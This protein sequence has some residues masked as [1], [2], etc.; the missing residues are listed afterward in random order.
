M[1]QPG[2][3]CKLFQE[4]LACPRAH[5]GPSWTDA[6]PLH[7]GREGAPEQPEGRQRPRPHRRGHRRHRR[8]RRGQVVAG[9]RRAL[10]R[11]PPPLR[12]DLQPLR[13]A[14]PRAAR[15]AAG[16]AD[17]G[18]APG[19]RRRPHG[20]RAHLALHRRHHDLGRRL[21]ARAL[22]AGGAPC[23]AGSAASRSGAT[24]RRRS[25][26]RS[27]PSRR[28]PDGARLLPAP[29]REEGRHRRRARGL[30]EG[31]LPARPG[32]AASRSGSRTRTSTRR[33]ASSPSC[34]TASRSSP[35][36]RQR[37]VDSLE[38][39]LRHGEGHVELRVE[40]ETEP[41]RFSEA[42]HCAA[43]RHRLRRP[44][45]RPLLLQPPRRR[46]RDLQGLRPHDGDRPRPRHP[47][48]AQD[49]RAGLRQAVPDELL[50][51]LPGRPRAA[52]CGARASRTTCP[53]P[54]CRRSAKRL[55]WDGEPGGPAELAEEVV[56]DRRLLPVARVA[57]LPMHVRVFLSR[58]RSYRPRAPTA[59]A[60]ASRPRRGSS[61]STAARCPRSRRCRWPRPSARFREWSVPGERPGLGAAAARDPRPA[62][63]PR[64]RRPRLPDARP[65]VAHALGRRGAA[66]DAGDGPRR[67]AHEHALRA[68]RA[69]GR[70]SPARRGAGCPACCAASPTRATRWS[71]SSTTAALIASADHVIDLG[72]GPGREGGEVVYEGPVAGLLDEPRSKTGAYLAGRLDACRVPPRRREPR[73]G[74][75]PARSAARART[76]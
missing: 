48:P 30:R 9:L 27:S 36:E 54:S 15:P 19:G 32:G 22:R 65:P 69:L 10:R 13:A 76:T 18:R 68:R 39:A 44:L 7:R 34:S 31:R 25:S 14:V 37:I 58:Y 47:R 17:R 38:A 56:R 57:H 42:L 45:A 4:G 20:A 3:R 62:A 60:R 5:P 23:T 12:R 51:R 73:P 26:T 1:P 24:R 52:S 64:G 2:A 74:A 11:G 63:L 55:V 16:R 49:D 33:T 70:P 50:Q 59:A 43:L 71:S 40:G 35:G 41:R 72:P 67:L 21:P 28:G 53:A 66:R 6:P 61:A 8:R 46:L 75:A 29:R